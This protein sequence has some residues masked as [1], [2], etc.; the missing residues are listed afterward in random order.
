MHDELI[1]VISS[2]NAER[3]AY[4]IATVVETRQAPDPNF[5]QRGLAASRHRFI[6]SKQLAGRCLLV[7]HLAYYQTS[8]STSGTFPAETGLTGG[9]RRHGSEWLF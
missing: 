9:H 7:G 1:R 2:L 3:R 8:A 4:A 6:G 5:R